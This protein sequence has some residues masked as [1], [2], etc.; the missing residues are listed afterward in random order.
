MTLE[1]IIKQCEND[2]QGVGV[3]FRRLQPLS[4]FK[5]NLKVFF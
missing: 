4:P 3:V 2:V 1:A 5:T